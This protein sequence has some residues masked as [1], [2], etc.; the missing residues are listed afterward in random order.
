ML[1]E[2][3]RKASIIMA[4]YQGKIVSAFETVRNTDGTGEEVHFVE[5]PS[6]EEFDKYKGDPRLQELRGLRERAILSTEI[7]ISQNE[8]SY[9]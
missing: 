8:K 9:S 5:F 1:D 6:E 3:E 7:K 2:F 4:D